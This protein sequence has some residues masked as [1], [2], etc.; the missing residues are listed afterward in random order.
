MERRLQNGGMESRVREGQK[1]E[2]F[3]REFAGERE[4][5]GQDQN[6]MMDDASRD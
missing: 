1:R 5:E 3:E 4:K 6:N 2:N